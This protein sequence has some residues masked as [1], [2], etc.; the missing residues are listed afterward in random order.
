[1]DGAACELHLC[2]VVK[3]KEVQMLA[4]WVSALIHPMHGVQGCSYEADAQ[5]PRMQPLIT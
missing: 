3:A 4:F 2:K 1:M 5:I